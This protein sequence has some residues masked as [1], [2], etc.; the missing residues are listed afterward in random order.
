[1]KKKS[2]GPLPIS[3][4][5]KKQ[6]HDNIK[7]LG[8]SSFFND[9]GSEMV[10]PILPFYILALGGGGVAVGLISGLKEG[11]SSLFK[12][13]GG[14]FS[15]R[16]GNRKSIILF[17]YFISVLFKFLLGIAGSWQQLIAFVSFERFGKLRDAPRDTIIAE[18]T[19]HRG[20]WFGFH[21][22]MDTTGAVIG[23]LI[24]LFLLWKFSFDYKTIIF[25]AAG[26]SLF[27]I[28]TISK[29]KV[30]KIKTTERSVFYGVKSLSSKLK[31]FIFVA[32]VFTFANFG[33]YMFLILRA[34]DLTGNIFLPLLL[35][36]IMNIFFASFA[37]PFGKLSDRFERK[38]IL[39][40]GYILFL[41]VCLGFIYF[42]SLISLFF[43]FALYGLVLAIVESNQKAFVAD[44]A[45]EMKGTAHGFYY[46][47]IGLVGI[48]AGVIAGILWNVSSQVMFGYLA[49]VSI[50]SIILLNFLR[51]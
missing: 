35:Y 25:I 42:N 44:L 38:S 50:I 21:K 27:S 26:F 4:K 46:M 20:R 49:I 18:S 8:R 34:K 31:Y 32:A 7:L 29:L 24:V 19:A 12:L 43:L 6:R 37:I 41:V 33:M 13:F 11:F 36:A 2:E 5:T 14:Y 3:E 51:K 23:S 17:G 9:I 39:L 28:L 16:T 48:P 47:I 40:L 1:M 10:A 30:N 45:G 22:M 15:D